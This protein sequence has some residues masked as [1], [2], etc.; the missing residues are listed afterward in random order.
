[1]LK[2][3][4]ISDISELMGYLEQ[5]GRNHEYYYHYTSWDSF[6]KIYEGE[7]FLLT[8]GNSLSINDQHEALMKGAW[9]EW[10]KTYIGSFSYGHAENMAMWGL[11]GLPAEDAIRIAISRKAMNIWINDIHD[12]YLWENGPVSRISGEIH[13]SDIVYVNGKSNSNDLQLTNSNYTIW[14][15]TKVG[16]HGVDRDPRMTG[17]IKNYAWRY[18]NEVRLH[19][20]LTRNT[21]Y[22]KIMIKIP[23]AVLNTIEIT[24]GPSFRYKSDALYKRL[25]EEGKINPSSFT[26]LVH[27]RPLCSFC[28]NSPFTRKT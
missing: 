24:T 16:L 18:E 12:V 11:Y 3:K 22:E 9:E 10:N 27:Y 13:L 25:Y 4:D 19:I 2:Y 6:A 8:R 23:P 26:N 17:Y 20:H 28:Q 21:G 15:T 1:M 5:K 7:S 14:T